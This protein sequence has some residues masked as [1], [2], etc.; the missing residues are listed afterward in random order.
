MRTCLRLAEELGV[1]VKKVPFLAEENAAPEPKKPKEKPTC[2]MPWT[3]CHLGP[4]GNDGKRYMFFCCTGLTKGVEYDKGRLDPVN[5]RDVWNHEN[6][7]Y[8]RTSVNGEVINDACRFCLY[9]DWVDPDS[10]EHYDEAK[11]K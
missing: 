2:F 4:A 3:E 10:Q 11:M 1:K 8:I 7:Q 6:A 9:K 5:F